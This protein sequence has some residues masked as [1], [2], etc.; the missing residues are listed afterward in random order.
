MAGIPILGALVVAAHLEVGKSHGAALQD[1]ISLGGKAEVGP[2]D[3]FLLSQGWQ[4][5]DADLSVGSHDLDEVGLF[6]WRIGVEPHLDAAGAG[7][8]VGC[9][10]NSPMATRCPDPWQPAS[11]A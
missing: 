10:Q 3:S 8:D 5:C 6:C 7:D 9:C 11:S 2:T 4:D 1:G